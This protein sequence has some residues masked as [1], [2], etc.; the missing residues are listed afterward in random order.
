MAASIFDACAIAGKCVSPFFNTIDPNGTGIDAPGLVKHW[1]ITYEV[2]VRV[3]AAV[4][5]TDSATIADLIE[6]L[7]GHCAP[8]EAVMAMVEAGFLCREPG[9]IGP[10]TRIYLPTG[11]SDH[12]AGG[13][14]APSV[15]PPGANEPGGSNVVEF[16]SSVTHTGAIGFVPEVFVVDFADRLDLPPEITGPIIYCALDGKTAYVGKSCRGRKRILDPHLRGFDRL[17][18]IRD[19]AGHMTERQAGVAERILGLI[20]SGLPGY[21]LDKG[22]LPHG[23]HGDF[24]EY[25][26]LRLFA[27]LGLC[28]GKEAGFGFADVPVLNLVVGAEGDPR[29]SGFEDPLHLDGT[30]YHLYAAGIAAQATEHEGD[31]IIHPGSEVRSR[32]TRSATSVVNSLRNEWLFSGILVEEEGRF[33]LTEP[34]GFSSGSGAANFLIGSKGPNLSAWTRRPADDPDCLPPAV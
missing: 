4:L 19:A 34:V 29:R 6:V 15:P 26:Q 5:E 14:S 25:L 30:N 16:R 23:A 28:L 20:V 32:L 13:N 24:S 3:I 31:W 10:H 17:L 18:V 8:V 1:A 22:V 33:R 2:Q 11:A 9:E 12:G 21:Q 7:P 27:A